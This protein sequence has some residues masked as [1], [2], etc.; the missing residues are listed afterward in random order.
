MASQLSEKEINQLGNLFKKIDKNGDGV[1]TIEEIKSVLRENQED[2]SAKE[3]ENIMGSLDTD[4]NGTLNYTG[5][6]TNFNSFKR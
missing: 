6:E 1:L 2:F 3:I 4:G 5:K